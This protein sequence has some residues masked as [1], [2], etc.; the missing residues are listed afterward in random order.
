LGKVVGM[1]G[2]YHTAGVTLTLGFK[3]RLFVDKLLV[4]VNTGRR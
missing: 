3:K 4:C 2:L 1:A